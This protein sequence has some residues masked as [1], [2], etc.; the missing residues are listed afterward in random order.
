LNLLGN[1]DDG[2]GLGR[3][4]P[5]TNAVKQVGKDVGGGLKPG[6]VTVLCHGNINIKQGTEPCNLIADSI[7]CCILA[8]DLPE[9]L[10]IDK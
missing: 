9:P 7:L 1:A 4:C 2:L 5:K 6:P 8:E 10:G 3:V